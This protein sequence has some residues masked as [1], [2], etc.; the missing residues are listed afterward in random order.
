MMNFLP[1]LTVGSTRS[2][3]MNDMLT[4]VQNMKMTSCSSTVEQIAPRACCYLWHERKV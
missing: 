1:F 2:E 4:I 3:K